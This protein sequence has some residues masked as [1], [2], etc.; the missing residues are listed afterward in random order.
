MAEGGS[1]GNYRGK[2]IQ[3]RAQDNCGTRTALTLSRAGRVLVVVLI[4]IVH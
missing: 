4:A 1:S 3:A 2:A